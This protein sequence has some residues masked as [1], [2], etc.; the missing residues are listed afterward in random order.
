MEHKGETIPDEWGFNAD[1][2]EEYAKRRDK[3]SAVQ[4]DKKTKKPFWDF[5]IDSYES[6][7]TESDTLLATIKGACD[8]VL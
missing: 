4:N 7:K 2:Y 1:V 3:G 8:N 6:Q 5:I